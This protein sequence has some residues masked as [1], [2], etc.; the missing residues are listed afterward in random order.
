[1]LTTSGVLLIY[2][3]TTSIGGNGFL[4]VYLAGLVMSSRDLIHKKSLLR[5]HDGIAWL[6]Q[7]VMFLT[8]G[9]QVFPSRLPVIAPMGLLIAAFLIVA[10]RPLSVFLALVFTRLTIR[11]KLY[12]AWVGLRGAAPI[13][14]ATFPLLAMLPKAETIFNLVFFIVLTSVLLQGTL[15]VPVAKLLRVDAPES[16]ASRSPLDSILEDGA[17][18]NN[19][20]EVTVM[21][22]AFVAHKRIVD[23]HLPAEILFLLIGRGNE[24]VIPRGSI[25]LLPGDRVLL[26]TSDEYHAQVQPLFQQA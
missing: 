13:I 14:L 2:G 12:I 21:E 15:I 26:V 24:I 10:A 4:A 9:L 20:L 25:V 22:G 19:L 11:E 17:I 5:F 7:I 1:V 16:T 18:S 8:L 3:V 23:L 6:M